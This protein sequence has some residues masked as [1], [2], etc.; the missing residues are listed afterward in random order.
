MYMGYKMIFLSILNGK[1]GGGAGLPFNNQ[2]GHVA[3]LSPI[4][5]Y[6]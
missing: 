6:I 1:W 4:S 2:T 5:I 3:F